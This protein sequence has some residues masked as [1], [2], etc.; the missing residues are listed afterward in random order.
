[1]IERTYT[2]TPS[3]DLVQPSLTRTMRFSPRRF[4]SACRHFFRIC[5][6]FDLN[7]IAL[8]VHTVEADLFEGFERG[9]HRTVLRPPA[10]PALHAR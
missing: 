9:G 10:S 5:P 3:G 4:A 2:V 6:D 8:D 7:A 1:M